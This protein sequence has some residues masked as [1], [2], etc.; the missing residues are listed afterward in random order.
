MQRCS[1]TTVS[2]LTSRVRHDTHAQTVRYGDTVYTVHN[3]SHM[4]AS[5]KVY[6]TDVK[7]CDKPDLVVRLHRTSWYYTVWRHN[8]V[9]LCIHVH[10][11]MDTACIQLVLIERGAQ[12]QLN[13]PAEAPSKDTSDRAAA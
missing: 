13:A 7:P 9:P 5:T 4:R 2:Q 1:A 6:D 12:Q 10:M 11:Y 3:R 8:D